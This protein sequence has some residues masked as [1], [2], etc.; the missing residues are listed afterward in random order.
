MVLRSAVAFLHGRNPVREESPDEP[1]QSYGRKTFL[2]DL[3]MLAFYTLY[4]RQ[5]NYADARRRHI[6]A[7]QKTWMH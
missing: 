6:E 2:D 3:S 4:S 1:M 7:A 5:P